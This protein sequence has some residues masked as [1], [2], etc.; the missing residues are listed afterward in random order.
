MTSKERQGK[1][2]LN[3]ILIGSVFGLL[4]AVTLAPRSG[5]KARENAKK[6]GSRFISLLKN[7]F[8]KTYTEI[9]RFG[10][11]HK[12]FLAKSKESIRSNLLKI[13]NSVWRCRRR[14]NKNDTE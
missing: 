11:N 4:S 13:R 2:F 14:G 5:K 10:E 7:T 6:S 12:E 3:G 9:Q 1:G 8:S